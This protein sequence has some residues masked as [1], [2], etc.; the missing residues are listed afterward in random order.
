MGL[1]LSAVVFHFANIVLEN[2]ES[3][4]EMKS[5]SQNI[6]IFEKFKFTTG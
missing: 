6:I 3:P 2:T 1:Q 4:S 5:S